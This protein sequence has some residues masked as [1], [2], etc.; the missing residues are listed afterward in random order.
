[1]T[2]SVITD[3]EACGRARGRPDAPTAA[4]ADAAARVGAPA[5][6]RVRRAGHGGALA[7]AIGCN[8]AAL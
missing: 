6:A 8:K 4:L 7:R 5:D 3:T 2:L 1:M